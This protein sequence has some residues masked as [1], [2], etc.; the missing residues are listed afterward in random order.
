MALRN[1]FPPYGSE[2]LGGTSD[3]LVYR[4]AFAGSSM[5]ATLAMVRSFL[6]EEG[7][8]EIPIPTSAEQ[9]LAFLRPEHGRHP[10]L[11]EQPDYPHYPVRLVL[12]KR[13]R[14]RR[15]LVVELYNE[16]AP[17]ALLRFHRRQ[18]EQR[19]GR[20]RQAIVDQHIEQ[21]GAYMSRD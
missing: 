1:E 13:D 7:Y 6:D 11:F 16:A 20:I 4:T 3:G 8:E 15:K 10:H 17:D 12:P 19:E 5:D 2:V 9:M 18:C 21:Y 14:L